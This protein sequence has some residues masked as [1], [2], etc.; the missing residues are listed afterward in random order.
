M[1]VIFSSPLF[2]VSNETCTYFVCLVFRSGV[3]LRRMAETE[4]RCATEFIINIHI[5]EAWFAFSATFA[6]NI[7]LAPTNS[8]D[9]ITLWLVLVRTRLV[10]TARLAALVRELVVIWCAYVAFVSCHA[11]FTRAFA[12]GIAL[13]TSRSGRITIA[14]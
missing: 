14:R 1:L 6:L 11:W 9:G 2:R 3:A 13:E 12:L 7:L 4:A 10:T 8:S 5:E